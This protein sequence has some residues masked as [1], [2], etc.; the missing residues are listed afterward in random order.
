M[1]FDYSLASMLPFARAAIRNTS[2]FEIRQF[3]DLLFGELEKAEVPGVVRKLSGPTKFDFNELNCSHQLRQGTIEIFFHMVHRGFILPEP[4]GFPVS[5]NDAR[6][7]RTPSGTAWS[8]GSD[9]LPE[10]VV[11]YVSYLSG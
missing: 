3:A 2:N 4:Q 11:E 1:Q 7:W 10:D 9:P 6:Y 8:Q 5:F